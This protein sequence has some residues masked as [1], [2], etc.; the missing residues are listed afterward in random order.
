M[1]GFFDVL[2]G[3]A[4]GASLSIVQCLYGDNFDHF[5]HAGSFK[6][7][8]VVILI[9]LVLVRIH[10]EPADDC[11]CFDDSVAFAGVMIGVELGNWHFGRSGRAWNEPTLAT[12]PFN[13]EA[14]GWPRTIARIVIG[15]LMVF[16]WREVMK[17]AL[18]KSLPPI[19]RIVEMLGLSLPRRF[20]VQA[21]E[22]QQVP[23]QK[24]DTVL[25][26]VS[27]IPSLL[28]S[29]RHPRRSRSVSVGPQSE[30][31]AY[32]TLAYRDKRRR[33]SKSDM[34]TATS[35]IDEKSSSEKNASGYFGISTSHRVSRPPTAG[36]PT[37]AP[38][39]LDLYTSMTGSEQV[40]YTPLTPG[41]ASGASSRRPS[42]ER[43]Q[44]EREEREMFSKLEKPRVRY[45]VEVVTKLIVYT[46]IAWIAVEGAPILFETIGLGLG[47]Q[48]G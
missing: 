31:D 28:T 36:L 3:S 46:G 4:L 43:R 30:A 29:F 12:V 7:P 8:A 14:L 34:A 1:H 24:D 22:Y 27:E 35:R 15:V 42:S 48:P 20:F 18:L 21:S 19:F 11:P 23:N 47:T 13:L 6:A 40:L 41:T 38:S 5:I 25:P 33:Q 37:P 45:D 32:E 10:P 2:V 39:N 9:I 26:A 44:D 16:A 17:P